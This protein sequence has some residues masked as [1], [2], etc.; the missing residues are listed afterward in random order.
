MKIEALNCPNCGAGVESDKT[1]CKFCRSRLKTMA[2]KKCLGLMFVGAK[3][4]GHC[5]ERVIR[6]EVGD[7]AGDCPRCKIKLKVLRFGVNFLRE[8]EKCDGLWVDAETFEE[9]CANHE[10]QA[11]VLKRIG[12]HRIHG[13]PEK[14]QYVPC[15]DCKHLMNRN[16]F[17]QISGVV[18]DICKQHGVWCDADE[19]PRIIEF[20]RKGGLDLARR[21]E[22]E[23]LELQRKE[24]IEL[25]R[26]NER[27]NA[28]LIQNGPRWNSA[29]SFAVREF[30]RFLFD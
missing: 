19:L 5:G 20:I 15:P 23:K 14:I 1:V 21:R 27:E 24:L 4:C 30:V 26:K 25:R 22:I 10:K 11:E 6:A 29:P 2:C 12:G 13:A 16:N 17:A 3:F 7:D 28:R 9:I 8:C 18:V